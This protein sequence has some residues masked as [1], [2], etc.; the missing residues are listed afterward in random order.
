MKFIDSTQILIRAGK[1]GNG[2]VS[3]KSS[4]GKPK[5]GPDGGD[6]GIGGSIYLRGNAQE[7]TLSALRYRKMYHAEDGARGGSNGCRGKS[8]E[9]LII[10]VPLGTVV[11]D[12]E[13]GDRLGELLEDQELLLVAKGGMRGLGN[14][15]WAT[16]THQTPEEWK[17]GQPGEEKELKLELKLLAD[18]GLAGFPN[19]GKSTFLS[20]VSAARPKIADYPFT[21]LTPNLGVV[22][23]QHFNDFKLRSLVVAD[24]PGLIEGASE[25]RG[26]GLEFLKHLERTALIMYVVDGYGLEQEPLE[27]LSVLKK[28]LAAFSPELA[29]K[30]YVVVIN[31]IDIMDEDVLAKLKADIEA[32][33]DEVL[34]MSAATRLNIEPVKN[35]LLELVG[36]EMAARAAREELH[37]LDDLGLLAA[38]DD[39]HAGSN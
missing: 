12:A 26:L 22:E 23:F 30:R 25:G 14:I 18:V 4:K 5:L 35:R 17:P 24:V 13:S 38:D 37:E 3:F 29:S 33:G 28:E 16:S 32:L 31:K 15:H 27:A 11:A 20:V 9:D 7:N 34:T 19:A 8:G 6:G 2:I 1:G 36:E 39:H 21:T 10:D